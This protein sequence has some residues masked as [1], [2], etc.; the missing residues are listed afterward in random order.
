MRVKK[1]GMAPRFRH[2][3]FFPVALCLL[4]A[5]ILLAGCGKDG[6]T[7]EA[8]EAAVPVMVAA[9]TRGDVEAEIDFTGVLEPEMVVNVVPK[10]GGRVA[11]V[12]VKDGDRVKAGDLLLR[13][14]ASEIEAQV[15][16]AEAG[17]EVALANLEKT[18]A[19][20]RV[21]QLEQ[22]RAGLQ[23]AEAGYDEAER[24][25]NNARALYEEGIVPKQ[26]LDQA[27]TQYIIA[28]AQLKQAAEEL[29]MAES[30]ATAEDLKIIEAQVSQAAAALQ[31][32][33]T[34]LADARIV[35]PISGTVSGV[36]LNPGEMAGPGTPVVTIN[37]LDTMEVQVN[38]TEKDVNRVSTGQEVDVLVP[39][40]SK[41]PLPGK[42][43]SISPVADPRT[44]TYKLKATLPNEDGR[45]K[46]GMTATIRAVIDAEKDTVVVPVEAL[47]V[48]QGRQVIY[49]V[50]E[51]LARRRAVTVG[52][53]NGTA[54]SVLEGVDPGEQV[55]VRGQHYLQESGKVTIVEGGAKQ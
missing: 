28:D 39:S 37:K 14:E 1:V 41:E 20:A 54:V 48:Q 47:L 45:L 10:I 5:V 38:L 24:S 18:R 7:P 9:A 50:E 44:K 23:M 43:H 8:A 26:Q 3:V 25:F 52:L 31:L 13:L 19:G 42:I 49:V 11:E 2:P 16:Q 29:K 12:R 27:E 46:A 53:E 40:V 51:G 36:V 32:A 15:A 21:E 22:C 55:V 34:Q 4:L 17:H 33:R 35:A 6:V 30:G